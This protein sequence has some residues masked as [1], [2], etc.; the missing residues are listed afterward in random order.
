MPKMKT[1][2]SVKKRF[3]VTATGKIK[4]GAAFTSHMMRNKPQSAKRKARGTEIACEADTRMIRKWMPYN[5]K[6][7]N[8]KAVANDAKS[9]ES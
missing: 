7:R 6:R 9:Q 5:R 3:S 4:R 1:K 8:T 2:S